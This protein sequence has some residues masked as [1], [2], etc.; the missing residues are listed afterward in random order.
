MTGKIILLEGTDGS[1]K[2]THAKKLVERLNREN[3]SSEMMS[4]PTYDTPTGRIVGQCYLGKKDLGEGDV[5]WFGKNPDMVEPEI[6]SLYYA[7][8]RRAEREKIKKIINSG[9]NLILD[10]YVESNMAHQGGKIENP[11]ERM[12]LINMIDNLEYGL[13]KMPRP[14]LTIFL[15]MPTHVSMTLKIKQR[16]GQ[17]ADRDIHESSGTHLIQAEKTYLEMERKFK[18]TKI[19]CAPEELNIVSLRSIESI[20]E[21][22]YRNVRRI[23]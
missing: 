2:G 4:F 18:W 7:A 16:I 20:A 12:E 22:I 10:R 15:H 3:F 8:N 1:G 9:T 19:E 11:Q 23:I 13:L 17:D 6:A 21:E 14:D 5:A